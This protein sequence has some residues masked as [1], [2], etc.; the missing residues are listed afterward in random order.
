[1]SEFWDDAEVIH[2]YT[3]AQ[4]IADGV[5]VDLSKEPMCREAGFKLPIAMTATAFSQAVG[6]LDGEPLPS[7]QDQKGRLWDVL[8]VMRFEAGRHRETD[9]FNFDVLVWDG[10]KHNTV[11]L[12]CHIG[13]GDQG[14][15]VLTVML[16]GED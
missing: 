10:K 11:H 12:W 16:Q 13:P 2:A 9:R 15:P 6:G 5:L 4:A 7:G 1:M 8:M 3:R 14:E